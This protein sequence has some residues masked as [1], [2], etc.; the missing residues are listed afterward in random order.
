MDQDLNIHIGDFGVA[1]NL[2]SS[3]GKSIVGTF[4]STAPEVLNGEKYGLAADIWSLGCVWYEIMFERKA[5]GNKFIE[6]LNN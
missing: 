6:V 2:N 4:D 5:F 3:I 1:K